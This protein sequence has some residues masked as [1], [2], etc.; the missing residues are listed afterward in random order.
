MS[1]SRIEPIPSTGSPDSPRNDSIKLLR[2]VVGCIELSA[3]RT[4]PKTPS[5]IS[6][7]DSNAA[8]CRSG[9][10]NGCKLDICVK[11][12]FR[13]RGPKRRNESGPCIS[14]GSC[15]WVS[16]ESCDSSHSYGTRDHTGRRVQRG[17]W[18]RC[19]DG[20]ERSRGRLG[21]PLA[22]SFRPRHRCGGRSGE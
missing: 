8:T 1:A 14:L 6:R 9:T 4:R 19:P 7:T 21:R 16:A 12:T 13:R 20:S 22:A 3:P 17:R 2:R 18:R 11:I 5:S 15:S 10:R